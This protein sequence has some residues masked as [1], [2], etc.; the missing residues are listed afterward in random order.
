MFWR[1][2]VWLKESIVKFVY[3]ASFVA[4]S[5]RIENKDHNTFAFGWLLF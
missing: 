3:T 1:E 5:A 4:G 2:F